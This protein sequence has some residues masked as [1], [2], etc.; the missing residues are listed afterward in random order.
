MPTNAQCDQWGD[1][2]IQ[3]TQWHLRA[4]GVKKENQRKSH[5]E[6]TVQITVRFNSCKTIKTE[7]MEQGPYTWGKI[8]DL[9]FY[10]QPNYESCMRTEYGH[11]QI[12]KISKSFSCMSSESYWDCTPPTRINEILRQRFMKQEINTTKKPKELPMTRALCI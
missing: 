1:R 6:F 2:P 3:G 10:S 11:C 4:L 12:H 8:T 5:K 9:D 7:I